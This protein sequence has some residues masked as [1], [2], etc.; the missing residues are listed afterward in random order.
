MDTAR[1]EQALPP[2]RHRQDTPGHDPHRKQEP[3]GV[4]VHEDV[5]RP[6]EIDLVQQVPDAQ[7]GDSERRE[8]AN[9]TPHAENRAWTRW[10]ASIASRMSSS[11]CAG[12]SGSDS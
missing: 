11:E 5:P 12:D 4:R 9:G 8:Y 10:T 6:R 7:A 1:G 2:P 3:A